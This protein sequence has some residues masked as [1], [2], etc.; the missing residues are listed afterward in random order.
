[1]TISTTT[2]PGAAKLVIPPQPEAAPPTPPPYARHL[3]AEYYGC[4]AAVLDDERALEEVLREAAIAARTTILDVHLH[5]FAPQ[6]VSGVVILAESHLAIHTW[7]EHGYAS[8]E[9]YVCGQQAD[10]ERGHARLVERLRPQHTE[11]ELLVR[12]DPRLVERYRP[13]KVGLNGRVDGRS[14]SSSAAPEHAGAHLAVGQAGRSQGS[15]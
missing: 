6:G 5:K 10:P 1:M 7:P 14:G 2:P 13:R 3:L 4:E 11:T 12:G 9:L 8:I 15:T